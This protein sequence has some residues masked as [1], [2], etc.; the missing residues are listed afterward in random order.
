[1]VEP[2]RVTMD[3]KEGVAQSLQ[4]TQKT[5][6]LSEKEDMEG[7]EQSSNIIELESNKRGSCEDA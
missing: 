2:Y 5:L 6:A 4:T 1:M 3:R 7:C